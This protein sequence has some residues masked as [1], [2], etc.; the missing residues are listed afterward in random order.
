VLAACQSAW[1]ADPTINRLLELVDVATALGAFRSVIAI[2]ADRVDDEPLRHNQTLA[3]AVLLL[4]GRVDGAISLL[5]AGGPR[6]HGGSATA[7]VVLPFLLIGAG[8]AHRHP[9][10]EQTVLHGLLDQIDQVGRQ[11]RPL[12]DE[13]AAL[14]ERYHAIAR[15]DLRL[16]ALL[17]RE[18][19]GTS[20]T[21]DQRGQWLRIARARVDSHIDSV[22]NGQDRLSYPR[23][24]RLAAGCAEAIKLSAGAA[25]SQRYIDVVYGR[26]PRHTAFTRELRE[27]VAQS[28]LL[29][30]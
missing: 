22:V 4:A 25:V 7:D 19:N 6:G 2:E 29:A 12:G 28:P 11:H 13:D 10:W 5:D 30:Q 8:N 21:V 17:V 16:S 26:Y 24:A 14:G 3:A 1:R 15:G 20:R 18:L 9:A 27:R 23:A